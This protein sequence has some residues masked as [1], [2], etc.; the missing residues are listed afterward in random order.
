M[1][2][3]FTQHSEQ[4]NEEASEWFTLMQAGS[5][6]DQ[7]RQQLQLWLAVDDEHRDAYQ[8]LEVIWSDLAEL[9]ESPDGKS[10]RQSSSTGF[11]SQFF[12]EIKESSRR[13]FAGSAI[14]LRPQ[15]AMAISFI[16]IFAGA[17]YLSQTNPP[18]IAVYT[19]Q[20][21]EIMTI[22]LE[23]GSQ[24]TLGAKSTLKAWSDETERHV[25]LEAG[26]AFFVVTQDPQR[27]F[28]VDAEDTRIKVVG[29][30]FDVLRSQGRIRV[31]V[32]EG[33]VNV[34]SSTDSGNS[35]AKAP[36]VLTK[37]L[38]VVKAHSQGFQAVSAISELELAAWRQGR[39]FY[40]NANLE[41]VISD[42]NRYFN[43]KITLEAP[44]LA[45]MKVTVAV[46]IDQIA[47]L[48]DML[49]QTLPIT[50]RKETGNQI[51]ISARDSD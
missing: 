26:Q 14:G 15:I 40:R 51:K 25:V 50:I 4:I 12:S 36:L 16:A 18:T 5:V 11:L 7:E 44:E 10:L 21:G 23:D 35:S 49:S 42:A 2:S 24:I 3:G 33:V 29:T 38:Q 20:T 27:P 47:F 46:S 6:S 41:D 48:P 30:R 19:T 17:F 37:G 43:G 45:G 32:S 34:S 22:T 31:A 1:Q 8:Q 39:L 9:S 13:F 28:W